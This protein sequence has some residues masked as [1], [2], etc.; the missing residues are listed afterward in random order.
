MTVTGWKSPV[1]RIVTASGEKLELVGQCTMIIKIGGLSAAHTIMIAR[2]LT[3]E[4]LLG[5]DFLSHHHC[6]LDLQ[7]QV[8]YAGGKHVYM[9]PPDGGVHES[10]AVCFVRM[11]ETTE[12]PPLLSDTPPCEN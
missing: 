10:H 8:L 9:C 12:G 6:E 2:S 3:Q 11:A 4:C 7:Q 5:A 1:Q